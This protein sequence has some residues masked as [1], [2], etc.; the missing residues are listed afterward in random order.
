[1]RQETKTAWIEYLLTCIQVALFI[2][3]WVALF[4]AFMFLVK[5]AWW[6]L[7]ILGFFFISWIV[8]GMKNY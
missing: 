4:T 2:L 6:V 8:Y 7:P 3:M 5:H 1:M